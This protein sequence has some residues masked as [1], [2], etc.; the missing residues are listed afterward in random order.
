MSG[1]SCD[2]WIGAFT[3]FGNYWVNPSLK[4]IKSDKPISVGQYPLFD[5]SE[6]TLLDIPLPV[7]IYTFFF[8]LDDTPDRI[9]GI[10]WYDYVNV[11]CQPEA[12]QMD[13]LPDFEALFQERIEELI[14]E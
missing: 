1:E 10:T 4:W 6:T 13:A 12:A 8:V 7:G 11:I 5:L 14:Q 9:F 2:W 3:P